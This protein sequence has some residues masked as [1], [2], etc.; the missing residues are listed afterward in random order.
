METRITEDDWKRYSQGD[1][2]IFLRKILGMRNKARLTKINQLYRSDSNFRNYVTRYLSQFDELIESA[3][4]SGQE[5]VLGASFMTSDA[6]KVYMIL[7]SALAREFGGST[8]GVEDP[9]T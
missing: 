9:S 5:G 3:R 2:S 4:R 6:G 7:Q 1:N 8:L